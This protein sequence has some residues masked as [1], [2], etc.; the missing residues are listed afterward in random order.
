MAS[1]EAAT[2]PRVLVVTVLMVLREPA[3]E[4]VVQNPQCVLQGEYDSMQ[5]Y[6]HVHVLQQAHRKQQ[7]MKKK[8]KKKKTK[9]HENGR[10]LILPPTLKLWEVGEVLP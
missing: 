3:T 5:S 10:G 7:Q 2:P 9:Q 4:Q 8:T 1:W 6:C